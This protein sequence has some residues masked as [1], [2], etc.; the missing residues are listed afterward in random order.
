MLTTN[1]TPIDKA[2]E[3]VPENLWNEYTLF[4]RIPISKWYFDERSV[5]KATEWN[6][7]DENLKE[8]VNIF[9]KSTYGTTTQTVIDAISRYKDHFKGKNGAVIG[10]QNPW[11]EI[12]S[13]RAGAASILTMEYQ[14]IKIKSEK[15][16][17]W[18]HPFEVG[19]NWTRFDRFFD[20]IIS[21]SSLEHSGL[22]RYGDPLDPWGDL[23]EMAKVRCL[24]KDNGVIIL[25]FP[26]GE[27][28]FC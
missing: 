10:S 12:F 7:I 3:K 9:K 8:G 27:G 14:E 15:A 28:N 23:R 20:F 4:G 16:I 24:L 13:L 19:K 11:A 25:G 1:Q 18:I 26:V 22:G 17:S 21:F 2:P 5:P 6:D